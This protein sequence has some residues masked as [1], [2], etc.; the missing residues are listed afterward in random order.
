MPKTIRI[1]TATARPGELTWGEIP[2]SAGVRD[3]IRPP[4]VAVANGTDSGPVVYVGAGA[5]G[6]EFNAMEAVRQ[7]ALWLRPQG[8]RGTV[9]FVPLQNRAA[10][11]A[12]VRRTP[13]DGKD[14]EDCFPGDPNGAPTDVLAHLLFEHAVA[15]ADYV[16]D[17]HTATRGGW[18]VLHALC[19]PAAAA[20]AARSRALAQAFGARVVVDLAGRAAG[21]GDRS[22][23]GLDRYL[24]VQASLRHI[25]AATI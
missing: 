1:G 2:V 22:G 11:D 25:V 8:M 23:W 3:A 5:H 17:L 13:A 6:D 10:F 9:V 21:L 18:N 4:L 12:R 14:L 19:G 15:R 16:L 24:S 20:H 7:A